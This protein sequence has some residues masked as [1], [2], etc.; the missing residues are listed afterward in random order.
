MWSSSPVGLLQPADLGGCAYFLRHSDFLGALGSL[1]GALRCVGADSWKGSGCWG[2]L[3]LA[4]VKMQFGNVWDAFKTFWKSQEALWMCNAFVIVMQC[5]VGVQCCSLKSNMVKS[6][7]AHVHARFRNLFLDMNLARKSN[8]L[9][10][11]FYLHLLC[12]KWSLI[13]HMIAEGG[14]HQDGMR[15]FF[16]FITAVGGPDI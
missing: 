4:T 13:M 12:M 9:L 16:W 3:G 14:C 8:S 10:F 15:M 2:R 6:G 5:A 1:Q 7:C 11:L